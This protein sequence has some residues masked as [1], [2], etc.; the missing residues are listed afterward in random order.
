MNN[1]FFTKKLIQFYDSVF[2][3]NQDKFDLK[4]ALHNSSH[5]RSGYFNFC[6]FGNHWYHSQLNQLSYKLNSKL[7]TFTLWKKFILP[8]LKSKMETTF[9]KHIPK[10]QQVALKEPLNSLFRVIQNADARIG[11]MSFCEMA[12]FINNMLLYIYQTMELPLDLFH[13][14][15]DYQNQEN[16]TI[17]S[18]IDQEVQNHPKAFEITLYL[19]TLTNFFDILDHSTEYNA[20]DLYEIIN[21]LLDDQEDIHYQHNHNTLVDFRYPKQLLQHKPKRIL[22]EVDNSGEVIYDLL[23]INHL[24]SYGHKITIAAKELPCFNDVTIND[25]STLLQNPILRSLKNAHSQ[26]QLQLI[27]N[28]N[29]TLGKCLHL[30]SADYK[31]AYLNADLTILKGQAHFD[32]MPLFRQQ[33]F[34]KFPISYKKPLLFLT[35]IR[36]NITKRIVRIF[37]GTTQFEG[38]M[39]LL[40]NYS[41]RNTYPWL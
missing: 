26:K 1:A 17:F 18:E 14:I 32:A 35:G 15:K 4:W 25:L 28:G 5:F 22:Y 13:D 19:A 9:L 24:L 41:H 37:Q 38:M 7:W 8:S 23:F 16:L 40:F 30:M 36:S 34:K 10:D 33:K 12:L 39:I 29:S 6:Q 27:S 20:S 2:A 3:I 21:Q 31:E 11:L